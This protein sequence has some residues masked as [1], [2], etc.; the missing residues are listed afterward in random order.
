[1]ASEQKS[2]KD[3]HLSVLP[4]TKVKDLVVNLGKEGVPLS[5]IGLVLRDQYAVPN[6]KEIVGKSVKQILDAHGIRSEVPEDLSKVILKAVKLH[7]HLV[8]NPT[9]FRVKRSLEMA[10]ARI[11]KLAKYYKQKGVLPAY[12]RYDRGRA[13]LLTRA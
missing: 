3:S 9:D 12:W 2:H 7:N 13:A 8:R 4:A 6:V 10:E 5:K 11:N 1:M